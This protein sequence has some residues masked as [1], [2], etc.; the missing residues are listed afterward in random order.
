MLICCVRLSLE[1]I[2]WLYHKLFLEYGIIL[3]CKFYVKEIVNN[4]LAAFDGAIKEGD[5]IL[6]VSRNY[7]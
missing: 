4:S 3:G 5:T 1:A 7:C 6:K 2:S